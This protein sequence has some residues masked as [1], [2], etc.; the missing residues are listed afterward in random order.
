MSYFLPLGSVVQLKGA[1]QRVMIVGRV[2]LDA[3]SNNLYD[4]SACPFPVGYLGAKQ[5]VLFNNA[6]IDK[7]SFIG[8]QD[9]EELKFRK[10]MEDKIAEQRRKVTE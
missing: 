7:V 2:Q 1:D 5:M 9:G 6:D 8:C 4:Y 10:Y 3:E